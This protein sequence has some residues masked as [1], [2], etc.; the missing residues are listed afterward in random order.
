[1]SWPFPGPH[2][3]NSRGGLRGVVGRA[4]DS[5]LL[6]ATAERIGMEAEDPGGAARPVDDPVGPSQDREDMASLNLLQRGRGCVL[7][8]GDGGGAV[9]VDL[10]VED[11]SGGEDDGALERVL[12]LADIPGPPI[13]G[14]A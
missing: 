4:S 10:E 9:A 11:R 1:M 2:V 3:T 12:Q 14:Q 7:G 5:E 13:G 8:R 6:E